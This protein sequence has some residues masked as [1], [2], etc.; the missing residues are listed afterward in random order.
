MKNKIIFL[1]VGLF[2]VSF[3]SAVVGNDS[4][5][6]YWS[7]NESSGT[8]LQDVH[9]NEHN[10]TVFLPVAPDWVNGLIGNSHDFDGF[11]EYIN[12]TNRTDLDFEAFTISMWINFSF[13]DSGEDMYIDRTFTAGSGDGYNIRRSGGDNKTLFSL[14]VGGT[15]TSILSDSGLSGGSF[16]HV[17]AKWDG[18]NISMWIN[19]VEQ[20]EKSSLS[21]VM[22][23]TRHINL[24]RAGDDSWY[25]NGTIDETG[26]WARNLSNDEI[27]D[28]YNSGSGIGYTDFGFLGLSNVT[29]SLNNPVNNFLTSN[30]TLN[31]SASINTGSENLLNATVKIWYLNGTLF[32]ETN[33]SLTGNQN[34]QTDFNITN[35]GLGNYTWNVFVCQ[36]NNDCSFSAP[37]NNSFNISTFVINN[38]V[39]QNSTLSGSSETFIINVTMFPSVT[40]NIANLVY[41]NTEH[42]GTIL[43]LGN[44]IYQFTRTLTIPII[45]TSENKSFYWNVTPSN[46]IVSTTIA[47]NQTINSF[48]ADD[49]SVYTK[50]LLNLT[51]L[52]EE[53]LSPI[54]GTIDINVNFFTNDTDNL[55]GSYNRTITY[56]VGTQAVVCLQNITQDYSMSY[57]VRHFVNTSYFEKYRNI[58]KATI[59]D[60]TPTQEI[61]LYN[62]LKSSG[63]VFKI[64]VVGNLFGDTGN[65]G[66]L[67]ETQRKY[68]GLNLFKLVE[69]PI[70]SSNGEAIANLVTSDI[71]Y[72]FVISH[73]GEVFGTFNNYQ[74]QC[75]NPTIDQCSIILNLAQST[76]DLEDFENYGNISQTFLLDRDANILYQTF[77]STDGLVHTVN[78]L[79]IEDDGFL[80]QTI[81]NQTIIGTSGTF[82]CTIPTVYHNSSFYVQTTVDGVFIGSKFF[83]QGVTIDWF[84]VDIF[85]ELLMFSSLV[86]LFIAHP[87]TIVLGAILGIT[88]PILFLYI[89]QAS[90][91]NIFIT[92]MFY[93]LAGIII[94]LQMRRKV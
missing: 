85:I 25:F 91:G 57:E 67:V 93:V 44:N 28:L 94:I 79:V 21:G 3:A 26:I 41:N 29:V 1:L 10:G 24:G 13:R 52:E 23:S 61:V 68:T 38:E 48:L 54:G 11:Q 27:S 74:V 4:L 92:V 55:V 15:S 70:T 40:P 71:I 31:F 39:W 65:A 47:H 56:G 84:G 83:S 90:F 7:F 77:S 20:A 8:N 2:M 9:L 18:S 75:A 59:N 43:S 64:I 16:S 49:C 81:C 60:E 12:I 73:E 19:G 50:V 5:I 35:L 89:G 72:N 82:T 78:S 45:G 37:T 66:L 36:A 53:T 14:T 22:S 76:G 42:S 80:N 17:L 58:Q 30:S 88:M 33:N 32:N 46:S 62:L 87:I 51:M 34:V 69:S 86:L 63:E 6:A